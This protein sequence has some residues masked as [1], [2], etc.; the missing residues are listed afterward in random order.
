MHLLAS[1]VLCLLPSLNIQGD[2]LPYQQ[3]CRVLGEQRGLEIIQECRDTNAVAVSY[4]AK[5]QREKKEQHSLG[6]ENT[7]LLKGCSTTRVRNYDRKSS[8]RP[9]SGAV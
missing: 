6:T 2:W 7:L 8:D 9:N 1:L 5:Q 4:G 3:T